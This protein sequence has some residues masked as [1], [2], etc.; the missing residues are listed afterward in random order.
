[1]KPNLA[2]ELEKTLG[3]PPVRIA[4]LSGGCVGEVYRVWLKDGSSVV[5]KV[6]QSKQA[7]LSCEGFMLN[8]LRKSTTLPVPQV[9]FSSNQLLVMEFLPGSSSFSPQAE[10]HAAQLLAGLH[11]IRAHQFGFE[12]STLIGGLAQPNPW[13]DS[14][15]TFFREQRLLF[16]A[17]E[18]FR[19][20]HLSSGQL[21][22]IETLALQLDTLLEEPEAPA[23]IH[24]DVWSGNVLAL[25]DHI[26]GFLDPAIYFGHPEIELAFITLFG[27]FGDRFFSTYHEIRPIQ[28][29]FFETRRDV[30]NLYPLLVHARLFGGSYAQ[31]VERTVKRFL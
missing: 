27:T 31:S 1:M 2:Q 23:L 30:Y 14:W 22:S 16:M 28:P 6:D 29:G 3:T 18:A 4:P 25:S 24:G 12:Q 20:G 9:L 7:V 11:S 15:I 19:V 13:S 17:R 21:T 8:Y 26:T 5:A 10:V